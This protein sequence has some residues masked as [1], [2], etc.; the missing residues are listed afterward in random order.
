MKPTK[1]EF[2]FLSSEI[3]LDTGPAPLRNFPG[4]E[5]SI[6]DLRASEGVDGD[7]NI[8]RSRSCATSG[9]ETKRYAARVDMRLISSGAQT[10]CLRFLLRGDK[11]RRR[12]ASSAATESRHLHIFIPRP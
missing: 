10:Q 9:V 2:G 12:K 1:V 11:H 8:P 7:W 3:D 4:L 5:R 6:A